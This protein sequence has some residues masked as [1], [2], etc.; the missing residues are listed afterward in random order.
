MDTMDAVHLTAAA[1]KRAVNP[2][3][4]RGALFPRY[5]RGSLAEYFEPRNGWSRELT[6]P[7]DY[8]ENH[9]Y[10]AWA[11]TD[12]YAEHLE[13]AIVA[14]LSR[15]GGKQVAEAIPSGLTGREGKRCA[16][17]LLRLFSPAGVNFQSAASRAVAA[18]LMEIIV[19]EV[20]WLQAKYLMPPIVRARDMVL[21]YESDD[22]Q[23]YP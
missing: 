11:R 3:R 20:T 10:E 22:E 13:N 8:L 7:R 6:L 16:K 15:A 17:F 12:E 19:N 23:Y 4:N 18:G 2:E 21:S 9:V 5:S 1:R 14:L